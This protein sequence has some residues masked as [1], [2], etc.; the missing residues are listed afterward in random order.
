MSRGEETSGIRISYSSSNTF[1]G[2]QRRFYYQKVAKVDFDPDF[3]DD[4]KALRI[5]KAYHA[6]LE[7]CNHSKMALLPA[8]F[9]QSFTENSVSSHTEQGLIA[10]MVRKYLNLHARSKL[11][12]EGIEIK[13]GNEVDY[14]GFID[15]VLADVNKNWWICDLKTAARLNASLLSRLSRDPQLNVY[16]HFAEEVAEKCG[17]DINKFQGVRYRVTTKATIKCATKE[18]IKEFAKRCFDRIEAYDIAVPKKDLIPEKV[19]ARFMTLLKDMRALEEMPE[20]KVPQNFTHCESYFKPCP[21]WSRCYGKTFTTNAEQY[22]IYDTD[23][24]PDLT[25]EASSGGDDDLDFL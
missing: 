5:G 22:V 10:G 15:V 1:Q 16:S 20:E 17:L 2:C 14:I 25:M 9:I 12:V 8:H 24:I 21:Y 7:Y 6:V 13:I 11:T 3:D 23:N 18:T 4:A 19:Y